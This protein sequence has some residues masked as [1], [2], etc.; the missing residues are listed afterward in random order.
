M[1]QTK[2]KAKKQRSYEMKA[3]GEGDPDDVDD[4]EEASQEHQADGLHHMVGCLQV[5]MG[6]RSAQVSRYAGLNK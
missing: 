3:N 5:V 2:I 4:C 6:A 1:P